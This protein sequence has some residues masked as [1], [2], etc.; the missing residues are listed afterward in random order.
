MQKALPQGC[1]PAG[2]HL[3]VSIKALENRNKMSGVNVV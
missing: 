1:L 3:Y 2:A